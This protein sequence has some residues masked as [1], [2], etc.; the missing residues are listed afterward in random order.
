MNFKIGEMSKILSVP[1]ETIRY[2]EQ[3]GV[4]FPKRDGENNY[5]HYDFA[6]ME[7]IM[8]FKW[9][10]KLNF[11]MKE[12][13]Q[14]QNG[15]LE[16]FISEIDRK[17]EE[18]EEDIQYYEIKKRR[19]NH[20][21]ATLSSIPYF[22]D[23]CLLLN[24][25]EN[26]VYVNLSCDENG[27]HYKCLEED[28]GCYN[29][30]LQ[31]LDLIENHFCIREEWLRG[32]SVKDDFRYGISIDGRWVDALKINIHPKMQFM[33]SRQCLYTVICDRNEKLFAID[34]FQG[35]LRCIKEDMKGELAGDIVGNVITIVKEDDQEY[36]FMEIW[37]PVAFP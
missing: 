27:D 26:Y 16:Y 18:L 9:F 35:I 15:D 28:D 30:V 22:L 6:D 10:R 23:H 3:K 17:R 2:F 31:Y 24:S 20:Y 13:L 29:Y 5:R 33:P 8:G 1:A 21:S 37:A 19:L 11:S 12:S 25:P 14:I 34:S 7:R 4:V 32:G 36:R